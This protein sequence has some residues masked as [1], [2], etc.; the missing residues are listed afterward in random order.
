MSYLVSGKLTEMESGSNF[1]LYNSECAAVQIKS[2]EL[3]LQS[4]HNALELLGTRALSPK[5]KLI[6]D[7]IFSVYASSSLI[8]SND[9]LSLLI[10]Q[11]GFQF[12]FHFNRAYFQGLRG[13]DKWDQARSRRRRLMRRDMKHETENFTDMWKQD[14]SAKYGL[15]GLFARTLAPWERILSISKTKGLLAGRYT[16]HG[17]NSKEIFQGWLENNLH[18]EMEHLVLNVDDFSKRISMLLDLH[19]HELE[20]QQLALKRSS[21]VAVNLFVQAAVISRCNKTY[22]LALNNFEDE[23]SLLTNIFR[24]FNF[25]TKLQ[26]H[27]LMPWNNKNKL[28]DENVEHVG[29]QVSHEGRYPYTSPITLK[30]DFTENP[31]Y[32]D[33]L[34]S[35]RELNK[36]NLNEVA[37]S[38][39]ESAQ[40]EDEKMSDLDEESIKEKKRQSE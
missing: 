23:L 9:V 10:A 33:K 18:K 19:G 29:K 25:E 16:V 26:L 35:I 36:G 32:L 8:G 27:D 20:N 6:F 2:K 17:Q 12:R 24:R 40:G 31:E 21:D 37:V 34:D 11:S 7:M 28:I 1:A 30:F 15:S 14:I 38:K 3:C 39:T 5:G 22:R 4:I 13:T